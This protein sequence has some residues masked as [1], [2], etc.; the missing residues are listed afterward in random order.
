MLAVIFV[1]FR[2]MKGFS[3]FFAAYTAAMLGI[4]CLWSAPSGNRYITTLVPLL[5]I[6]LTVGLYTLL[7]KLLRRRHLSFSPMC[8]LVPAVLL[9][10]GRLSDLARENR[11]PLSPQA[12]GFVDAAKAVRNSLPPETVVCSRKPS[13]FYVYAGCYVCNFRYTEDDAQLIRGLI[14]DR[15]DY[16]VI[17][18]LGYAAT[19]RYL[20]P[21]ILAHPDLFEVA[22]AFRTP[23]TYL[24]RF[25]RV[26]ARRK[27]A[28]E[29]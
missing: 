8:L 29:L 10:G 28:A 25:N 13:V 24:L 14:D 4:I 6:G 11:S 22:A 19:G 3:W 23:P 18:Q 17:D 26:E 7:E 20:L 27:I 12:A 16:V 15:V 9:A 5:E 2:R 1:G 21:A